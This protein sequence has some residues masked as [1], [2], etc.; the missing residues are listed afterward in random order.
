VKGFRLTLD[1]GVKVGDDCLEVA[2]GRRDIAQ[3]RQSGWYRA[4]LGIGQE[5]DS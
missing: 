5:R 2:P 1:G 4:R 3:D